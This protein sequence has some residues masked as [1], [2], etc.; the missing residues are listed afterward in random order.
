[1]EKKYIIRLEEF[2]KLIKEDNKENPPVET[3]YGFPSNT[4]HIMNLL[5]ASNSEYRVMRDKMEFETNS[6][7]L[8]QM[9]IFSQYLGFPNPTRMD[10]FFTENIDIWG[11]VHNPSK[12]INAMLEG[13]NYIWKYGYG[14][15]TELSRLQIVLQW[16]RV[17]KNLKQKYLKED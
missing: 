10:E 5:S 3:W 11:T 7:S 9:I 14:E 8:N 4:S 17:A 13:G 6:E 16:D 1:M 15:S 12:F 2:V